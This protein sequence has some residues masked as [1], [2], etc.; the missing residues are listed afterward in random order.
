MVSDVLNSL[1]CLFGLVWRHYI[2]EFHVDLFVMKSDICKR[3]PRFGNSARFHNSC[4]VRYSEGE[5]TT[6]TSALL[7]LFFTILN[8][9]F[10]KAY[11]FCSGILLAPI[12][13]PFLFLLM[14][15]S[16]LAFIHDHKI[17]LV[18]SKV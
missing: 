7:S 16:R 1:S 11:F 3:L 4:C 18:I 17:A 9:W 8:V 12:T 15:V 5:E 2:V 14:S 10:G 6:T 13:F